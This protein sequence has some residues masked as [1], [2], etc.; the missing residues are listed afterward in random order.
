MSFDK[1]ARDDITGKEGKRTLLSIFQSFP[2]VV[3]LLSPEGIILDTN[4]A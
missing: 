2:D 1:I 3:I 4:R